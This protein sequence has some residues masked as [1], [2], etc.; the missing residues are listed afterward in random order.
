[1]F[2]NAKRVKQYLHDHD[3]QISKEGVDALNFK[4]EAILQSAIRN[5]RGFKRITPTEINYAKEK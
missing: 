2:I 5:V 1:M 4:V 3:K